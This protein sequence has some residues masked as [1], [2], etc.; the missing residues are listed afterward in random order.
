MKKLLFVMLAI[1]CVLPLFAKSYREYLA[2]AKKYEEQK[3]WCYALGSYYD[4]MGTDELPENKKEAY[5]SYSKLRN[6]II[7]GNPG[8]GKFNEFSI[9]DEWKNLLIDAEKYGSSISIYD[10]T[11][12]NLERGALDYKT[13]TATYNAKIDYRLGDRYNHTI[14]IIEQGYKTVYKSDWNDLPEEWPLFSASTDYD[15]VYN[16]DG[17]LVY[18]RDIKIYDLE[19]PIYINAFYELES[20]FLWDH[21]TAGLYDYKFN[22]VDENGK[23]LVKGKRWL[24]G[25]G[26]KI[27]F[28]GISPELMDIIDSGK[29]FVNPVGCYLQY[30]KYNSADDKGGRTFM[31]NFPEVQLSMDYMVFICWNN[32]IDKITKNC[33]STEKY[34]D[35]SVVNNIELIPIDDLHVQFLKTEV[36]QCL[37][38]IVMGENPSYF[39]G[40]DLPVENISWYDAICFC[41][42]LSEMKGYT[43]VY[44]VEGKTS[45]EAWNYIPHNGKSISG[46][47]KQNEFADGFRLPT[48]EEWEYAAIGSEDYKYAG[49][50]NIDEVGWDSYGTT[51]L[52]AQKKPNGYGLY[53]MS[54]NVEELCLDFN[55]N[56]SVQSSVKNYGVS[57]KYCG[58]RVV[59]S[60]TEQISEVQKEK[61]EA[62]LKV[63]NN[64][65]EFVA[66]DINQIQMLKT[67]VPQALYEA[68]M[69]QNPSI[70][71]GD[72]LPVEEVS[73]YDAIYFCNKLSEIK[74]LTPVYSV[75][76]ST[77]IANWNYTPHKGK[78]I[79]GTV[80]QNELAD[81]FRLPTSEEWEYAAKGGEDYKYAGSN[82]IAEVA[83]YNRNSEYKSHP[84]A[85]KKPNGYGLYDMSGNVSEWCW[86]KRGSYFHVLRG[87]N[88][89]N[90]YSYCDVSKVDS[91]MSYDT[92]SGYGFR[93]VRRFTSEE[94]FEVQQEAEQKRREEEIEARRIIEEQKKLEEQIIAEEQRGIAGN[95][96]IIKKI[97]DHIGLASINEMRVQVFKT[98]VTQALYEAVMGNNPS[99]FKGDDLPVENISWYDAIYFCNKLSEIM[100]L[101]PVYIV[102]G[103]TNTADWKYTPHTKAT[104][105]SSIIQDEQANG[106]RLPTKEEWQYAAKGGESY[107][108]AGND[109]LDDLGW[110]KENSDNK[111]HSVAQKEANSYGLYDMSGNVKEWCWDAWGNEY[112]VMMNG[113]YL[114][115]ASTCR[116]TKV[117]GNL[118]SNISH[119]TG[120][121]IVQSIK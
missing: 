112:R 113:S 117:N 38:K 81:G 26:D 109:D 6:A 2:E 49:S 4:A 50:N 76:G 25:D 95:E 27:S 83:W 120:F 110:Y 96:K 10:I 54:G 28:S 94:V 51:N 87:G 57:N 37:Y 7:S 119:D 43:P 82:D 13:R 79:D 22:I 56:N 59:R 62:L 8:F 44:S 93:I 61:H 116:I 74:E 67:E 23:E 69:G 60:S 99:Y 29:A 66:I 85:Q 106:F 24:L 97:I 20:K 5:E 53:D 92:G 30:G 55:I 42:K 14:S 12:G 1:F 75:N 18:T 39:W 114:D 77:N 80:E 101:L 35:Y 84:V 65:L 91:Y 86:N 64:N 118:A 72:E 17:A 41:N 108:Y 90:S 70:Y 48:S 58:F 104:I 68:V 34:G 88:Y 105:I 115:D 100:G 45:I 71:K 103:S 47:I 9:H 89:L 19:I 98:E 121:R 31:K 46:I 21:E 32:K 16:I 78:S 102:N 63:V 40:N 36:T 33:L 11:I 73:W 107:K 52:V 3:R 15:A 111:T